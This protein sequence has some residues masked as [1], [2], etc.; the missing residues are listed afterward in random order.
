MGKLSHKFKNVFFDVENIEEGMEG[1]IA[2]AIDENLNK[3]IEI[4]V[5]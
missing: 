1:K 5:E 2:E 3:K 4:W